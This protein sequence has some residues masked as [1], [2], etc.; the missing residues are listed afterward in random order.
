MDT[1]S[2]IIL[3]IIEGI[4]EFLPVSS[5]GHLI[6]FSKLLALPD[7]EFTKTFQIAIQSGAILA[8]VLLYWKTLTATPEMWKKVMVAFM[9]TGIAGFLLYP[10]FKNIFQMSVE[11]VLWSLFLGGIFLIFFELIYQAKKTARASIASLS[12][13]QAFWIG[14]WQAFA[15]I[16]GVSRSAA[17]IVGGLVADLERKAAVEFSFLLAIPTII[18]AT[19]YD[20]L[21]HGSSF[22]LGNWEAL[23]V[24]TVVSFLAALVGIKFMLGFVEKHNFLYFGFYRVFLVLVFFILFSVL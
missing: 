3:G 20:L 5:T 13:R 15:I 21:R 8:V 11:L 19:A 12:Y 7:G 1:L 24:G 23:L 2:A 18:I 4:T 14:A 16:P 17:S 22:S 10:L 9:P 6:L